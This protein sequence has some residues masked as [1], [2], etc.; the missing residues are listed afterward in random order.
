MSNQFLAEVPFL[1]NGLT[2]RRFDA[3][4]GLLTTGL[5]FGF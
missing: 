1:Y 4:Y 3:R 5:V 2:A